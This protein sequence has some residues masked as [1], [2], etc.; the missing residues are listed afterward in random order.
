MPK[1]KSVPNMSFSHTIDSHTNESDRDLFNRGTLELTFK[2]L[3]KR[4][5]SL[6]L[7][8]QNALISVYPRNDY[9]TAFTADELPLHAEIIQ[10]IAQALVTLSEELLTASTGNQSR[11]DLVIVRS[12]LL[13]WLMLSQ[14]RPPSAA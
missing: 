1:V 6:A 11:N 14:E 10:Q 3:R 4:R 7:H 13:D 9:H 2:I 12:L 8:I 5:P